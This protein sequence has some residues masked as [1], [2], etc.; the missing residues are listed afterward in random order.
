MEYRSLF[1]GD[2]NKERDKFGGGCCDRTRGNGFKLNEGRF[3]LGIR[4]KLFMLRVVRQWHGV[5]EEVVVPT[6]THPQSG[7]SGL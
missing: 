7:W 5:P 1:S 2:C 3:R 6:H 4:K